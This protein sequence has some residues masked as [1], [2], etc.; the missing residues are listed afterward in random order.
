MK[1]RAA[2]MCATLDIQSNCGTG[3]TV[4]LLFNPR[5][6]NRKARLI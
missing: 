2:M 1:R 6:E 3:T 4:S 5:A